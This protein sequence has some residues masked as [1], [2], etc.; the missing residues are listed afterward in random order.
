MSFKADQLH[1]AA[2][3]QFMAD[4]TADFEKA[5][6]P[7]PR[8]ALAVKSAFEFAIRGLERKSGRQ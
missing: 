8:E 4:V 3:L 5:Q 6:R 1:V 2:A 7:V